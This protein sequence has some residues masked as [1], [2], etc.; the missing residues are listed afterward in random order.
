MPVIG[1]FEPAA[2]DSTVAQTY[3]K[4]FARHGHEVVLSS[5]RGPDSLSELVRG[6]GSNAKTGT[7]QE[8]LPS[9]CSLLPMKVHISPVWISPSMGAWRRSDMKM[10]S[11]HDSDSL[12]A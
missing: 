8:S 12:D 11:A 2:K 5:S 3:T 4:Y 6:I 7:V 10:S 1:R 9:S